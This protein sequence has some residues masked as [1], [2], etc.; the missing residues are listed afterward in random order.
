MS[1]VV[2]SPKN[3]YGE[4]NLVTNLIIT[5]QLPASGSGLA[6]GAF[7]NTL[8]TP[9]L[10]IP[11]VD[12]E[13]V[14]MHELYIYDSALNDYRIITLASPYVVIFDRPIERVFVP[15]Y[16]PF[17]QICPIPDKNYFWGRCEVERLIPLQKMRNERIAQIRRM[18]D[19]QASPPTSLA[20]FPGINDEMK[21]ALD[22]P[23]G[24]IVNDNP[25]AKVERL[26]PQMPDDLFKEVAA[27]DAMFDEM[28][29]LTNV[30][31]GRGEAGVRSSGHA[32]QLARLGSSRIKKR[33]MVVEDSLEMVA[34]LYL[35]MMQRYD[36]K[37]EYKDKDGDLFAASQF[38][39]DAIVKV[40]AHS[41]SP[42]FMEDLMEKA[43]MLMKVQAIKPERFIEMVGVPQEQVLV[44]ELKTEIEPAKAKAKQEADI[45]K[46]NEIRAKHAG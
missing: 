17:T 45:L 18:L 21:L 40:D 29:G 36:D 34:T 7:A 32:S 27:I 10:Y 14:K 15:E 26:A 33:A 12:E 31:Q 4:S 19:K 16:L 44:E 3:D 46:L 25:T 20:G 23:A 2:S 42:I 43:E 30:T 41:N 5:S 6:Q 24:Y 1:N 38:T 35:K 11:R 22:S 37:K 13:L 8:G 39:H 9:S 28:S